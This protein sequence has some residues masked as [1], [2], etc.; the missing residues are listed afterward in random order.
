MHDILSNKIFDKC[1]FL[2]PKSILK[3]WK[4]FSKLRGGNI[5]HVILNLKK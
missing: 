1:F 5:S 3:G 4:Q 2:I